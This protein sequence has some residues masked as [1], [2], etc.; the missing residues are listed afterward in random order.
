RSMGGWSLVSKFQL[1]SSTTPRTMTK[2]RLPRKKAAKLPSNRAGQRQLVFRATQD[3]IQMKIAISSKSAASQGRLHEPEPPEE[4]STE[5][6]V[7]QR[8]AVAR[9]AARPAHRERRRKR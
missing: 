2:G 8:S 1:Q 3:R 6:T 9:P 5:F 4:Y 7:A